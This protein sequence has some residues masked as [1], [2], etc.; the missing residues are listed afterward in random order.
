MRKISCWISI[1]DKIFKLCFI[2]LIMILG[3]VSCQ[4]TSDVDV[5]SEIQKDNDQIEK[6]QLPEQE[7]LPQI[8]RVYKEDVEQQINKRSI[9]PFTGPLKLS[10]LLTSSNNVNNLA[11]IESNSASYIVAE[12]DKI[13]DYWSVEKINGASVVLKADDRELVIDQEFPTFHE[14]SLANNNIALNVKESDIRDVLSAIAIYMNSCVIYLEE[15]FQVTFNIEDVEPI[16]ALELLLQS[17]D[18]SYIKDSDLIVVGKIDKLQ[19]EFFNQMILTRFELKHISSKYLEGLIKDLDISIQI[20]T[21]DENPRTI[22]AQ[23]TPQALSKVKELISALDKPE[24]SQDFTVFVFNLNNISAADAAERLE[25]FEFDD[26]KTITFNYP[27]LGEDLMIICPIHLKTK[28]T[29]ALEGLD[30]RGLGVE[31]QT[32]ILPV[33]SATGPYAYDVIKARRDLLIKIMSEL[34]DNPDAIQ[35]SDRLW[36]EEGEEYRVLLVKGSP[37]FIQMVKEMV[38]LIKSP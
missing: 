11:I 14:T 31:P 37:D 3:V 19:K 15:P 2:I 6:N 16:T 22:W 38:E 12:G 25:L 26:V 34:N 30:W 5:P 20:I 18:L 23:G 7:I 4:P 8:E 32:V 13:A 35:I 33:D 36:T 1:N 9:N 24:N 21:I 27:E 17:N 29:R 28:V 10:G